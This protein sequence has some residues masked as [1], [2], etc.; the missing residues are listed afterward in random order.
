MVIWTSQ[1]GEPTVVNSDPIVFR[2]S[3]TASFQ[4]QL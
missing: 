4:L 2:K 3:T 1:N